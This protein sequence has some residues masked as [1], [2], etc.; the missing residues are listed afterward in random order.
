MDATV[1]ITFTISRS[2]AMS[3]T[4][5]LVPLAKLLVRTRQMKEKPSDNNYLKIF[6][7]PDFLTKTF[8]APYL[9]ALRMP[10]LD[11]EVRG[12]SV[13]GPKLIILKISYT[14]S[15]A[16][17]NMSWRTFGQISSFVSSYH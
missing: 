5:A 7:F 4:N 9:K 14:N 8:R 3:V 11:G 12:R 1:A 2:L 16:V 6:L 17:L 15:I 13:F 10:S